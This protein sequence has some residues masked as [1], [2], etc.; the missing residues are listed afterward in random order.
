MSSEPK[1]FPVQTPGCPGGGGRIRESV[2]LAAYE[3]YSHVY[4]PQL[5]MVEGGCCGGFST[6]ELLAFLYARSFPPAEW[7]ERVSEAFQGMGN[8]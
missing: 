4:G 6:G 8:L 3:V 7:R 1:L 2:Y 5:A